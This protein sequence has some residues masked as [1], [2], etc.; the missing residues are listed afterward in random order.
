MQEKVSPDD[1]KL[2]VELAL[3]MLLIPKSQKELLASI[4]HQITSRYDWERQGLDADSSY[5]P[6]TIPTS[7]NELNA[8]C[9]EGPNSVVANCPM[10]ELMLIDGNPIVLPSFAIRYLAAIEVPM[11]GLQAGEILNQRNKAMRVS[12]SRK[13]KSIVQQSMRIHG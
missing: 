13:A 10:P 7:I 2:A 4:L 3:L 1:G 9:W 12:T 6:I 5:I 11:E 8:K